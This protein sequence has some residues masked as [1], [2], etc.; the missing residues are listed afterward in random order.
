MVENMFFQ[1]SKHIKMG[2]APPKIYH[3]LSGGKQ[4]L[5]HGNSP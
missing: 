2:N 3:L 4:V 1:D 5:V